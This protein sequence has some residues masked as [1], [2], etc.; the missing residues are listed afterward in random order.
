MFLQKWK[1]SSKTKRQRRWKVV[2]FEK[3][4]RKNKHV[5]DKLAISK[6]KNMINKKRDLFC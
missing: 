4:T 5:K 3:E 6:E 1:Y 2:G